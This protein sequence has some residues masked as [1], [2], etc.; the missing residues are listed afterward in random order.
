M[1]LTRELASY[2]ARARKLSKQITHADLTAAS[3]GLLQDVLLG[4]LP[5]GAVLTG[6]AVKITTYFT[7]GS[8]SAVTMAIGT[9]ESPGDPDMILDELNVFDT[10]TTGTW[11]KGTAGVLVAPAPLEG[12]IY[13]EFDADAGHTLLALTAGV[14]D[15]EVYFNVPQHIPAS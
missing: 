6:Y 1:S 10:T 15:V 14:I 12:L 13:A 8:A 3:N 11:I 4:R 9:G 2:N 7:G 5:P